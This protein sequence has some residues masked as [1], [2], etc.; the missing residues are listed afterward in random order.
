MPQRARYV[1]TEGNEV[2]RNARIKK[3]G[4][5]TVTGTEP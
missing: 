1:A 3:E 5:V 2:A 4:H